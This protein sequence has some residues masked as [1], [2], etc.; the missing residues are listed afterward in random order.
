MVQIPSDWLGRQVQV[1]RS[2]CARYVAAAPP[3][4][5]R[6]CPAILYAHPLAI[7]GRGRRSRTARSGATRRRKRQQELDA[8]VNSLPPAAGPPEAAQEQGSPAPLPAAAPPS[9]EPREPAG[10]AG[11]APGPDGTEWDDEKRQQELDA[12]VN[13]LPP[14][15]GPPEAAQEQGSPAAQAAQ[16]QGLSTASAAVDKQADVIDGLPVLPGCYMRMP[17]GCPNHYKKTHLWRHDIKAEQRNM[18]GSQCQLRGF[19]WNEYC[20]VMDVKMMFIPQ[21]DRGQEPKGVLEQQVR[22]RPVAEQSPS[23]G[24]LEEQGT[25][26]E[27]RPSDALQAQAPSQA[28]TEQ[29]PAAEQKP[30]EGAQEAQAPAAA[31]APSQAA[32]E[33]TPAAEQKPSEGAQEAQAPAAAQAPSQ[34]ATEQTPA[35][36]QK[37]S[38]GAQEAQAPAAAQAPVAEQQPFG[39]TEE[40]EMP[41]FQERR[42]RPA[43][44]R[45]SPR[46]RTG[47]SAR[48]SA[49]R[50]E[51]RAARGPRPARAPG[52]AS[53]CRT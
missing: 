9:G 6:P 21:T 11:G 4:C 29:T 48:S 12:E 1:E 39:A 43:G 16:S 35:A 42:P 50:R 44:A 5:C 53:S 30:S 13:S 33:Q 36:E 22:P 28:A 27:Q 20:G 3:A 17:T 49:G 31:Q 41:L 19:Y 18:T 2:D 24:A 52:R 8:E 7:R 45:P 40:R 34:A 14:A 15:A 10:A 32:T 47:P 46:R 37:P 51:P 25:A 38:E 23:E 26:V